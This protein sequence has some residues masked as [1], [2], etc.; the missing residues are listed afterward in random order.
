MKK[1]FFKAKL[2]L[3]AHWHCKPSFETISQKKRTTK[4][5]TFSKWVSVKCQVYMW[6]Y[7]INSISFVSGKKPCFK[8][9]C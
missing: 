4:A 5:K 8:F 1:V 7:R 3:R 2:G 6:H 9:F